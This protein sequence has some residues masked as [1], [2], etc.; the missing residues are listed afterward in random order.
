[1][2]EMDPQL[3]TLAVLPEDPVH[4][5]IPTH[6]LVHVTSEGNSMRVV[7]RHRCR[8]NTHLDQIKFS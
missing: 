8:Q 5:S 6:V 7:Y 2:R 1:M 4:W 3:E